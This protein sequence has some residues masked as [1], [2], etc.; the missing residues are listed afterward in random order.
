MFKFE[1]QGKVVGYNPTQDGSAVIVKVFADLTR[2]QMERLK[3]DDKARAVEVFVP[4]ALVSKLVPGSVMKFAG[5]FFSYDRFWQNPETR[6]TKF[7]EHFR[8]EAVDVQTVAGAVAGAG[9]RAA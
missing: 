5:T 8:F 7:Y 4:T 6:Q 3:R 2:E 9:V 1:L